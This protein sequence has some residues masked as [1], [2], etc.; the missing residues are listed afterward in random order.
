MSKKKPTLRK[1]E[2][3]VLVPFT[4][5]E[6]GLY[7]YNIEGGIFTSK[8]KVREYVKNNWSGELIAEVGPEF[9]D[10]QRALVLKLT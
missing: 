9:S 7:R 8:K 10:Q 1:R 5:T 4:T 6:G 3:V 2:Y